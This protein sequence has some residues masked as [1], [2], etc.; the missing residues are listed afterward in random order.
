MSIF[1]LGLPVHRS[2]RVD[3][4]DL[5]HSGEA[6]IFVHPLTFEKLQALANWEEPIDDWEALRRAAIRT[7]DERW[8]KAQDA[9]FSGSLVDRARI[10]AASR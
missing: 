10:W 8:S 6:G 9:R 4:G 3:P 1:S 5:L 7:F 2:R